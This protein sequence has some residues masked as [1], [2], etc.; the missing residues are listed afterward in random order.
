MKMSKKIAIT[1]GLTLGGIAVS[2]VAF[3]AW[4]TNDDASAYAEATS[5]VALTTSVAS[6][7]PQLYP[8]GSGDLNIT[9]NNSNP[10]PVRVTNI[11]NLEGSSIT[12]DKG[13]ACNASTGVT[14]ANIDGT[15]DV[16]ANGTG[17]FTLVDTV[18]MSNASDT[19]CQGAVFTIPVA[20]SGAS[21]S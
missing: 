8:G 11:S 19:T 17:S 10:Y 7:S 9:I 20:L 5:S 6:T 3:A 16:P 4:A 15:W 13:A 1:V 18:S 14:F 21:N 12:S 2:T